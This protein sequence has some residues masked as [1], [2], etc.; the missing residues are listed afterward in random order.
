MEPSA[1]VGAVNEW[2]VAPLRSEVFSRLVLGMASE[3]NT[4]LHDG[5]DSQNVR[6]RPH[7]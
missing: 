6:V 3:D 1:R 7:D 5:L 2:V 4:A